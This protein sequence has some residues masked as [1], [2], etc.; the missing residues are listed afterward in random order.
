MDFLGCTTFSWQPSPSPGPLVMGSD[1]QCEVHNALCLTR[2]TDHRSNLEAEIHP[3]GISSATSILVV[4]SARTLE[5]RISTATCTR[6]VAPYHSSVKAEPVEVLE[7]G[8]AKL[9]YCAR[10]QVRDSR[11]LAQLSSLSQVL[12]V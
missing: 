1:P 12:L 2:Q 8:T 10:I 9:A 11:K 5:V 7:A 4:S 3:A 6:K